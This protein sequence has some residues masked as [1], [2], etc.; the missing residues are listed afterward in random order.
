MTHYSDYQLTD[1]GLFGAGPSVG[2]AS[3]PGALVL[4][5]WAVGD[6]GETPLPDGWA[7]DRPTG[8]VVV[9]CGGEVVKCK[10]TRFSRTDVDLYVRKPEPLC[11]FRIVAPSTG[12]RPG[13]PVR[14]FVVSEADP[15]RITELRPPGPQ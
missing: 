6:W 7:F 1:A 5:G 14:L 15:E 13:A 4:E 9:A 11:A 8:Q 2:A 12:L 3:D 10:V